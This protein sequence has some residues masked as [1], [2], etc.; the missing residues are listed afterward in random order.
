MGRETF[1]VSI[2]WA[3][4]RELSYLLVLWAEGKVTSQGILNLQYPVF[5]IA[6]KLEKKVPFPLPITALQMQLM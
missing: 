3:E 2:V 5:N 4:G 1:E 6:S